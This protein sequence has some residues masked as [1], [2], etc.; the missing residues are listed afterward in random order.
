MGCAI[1]AAHGVLVISHDISKQRGD[2]RRA[3][4]RTK[5]HEDIAGERT[6]RDLLNLGSCDKPYLEVSFQ[7]Y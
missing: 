3:E 6:G 4:V 7:R 5:T 1:A 2:R